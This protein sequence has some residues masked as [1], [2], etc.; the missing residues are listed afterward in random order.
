MGS[1]MYYSGEW[2]VKNSGKLPIFLRSIINTSFRE[3]YSSGLVK[4]FP[5]K[6]L[7]ANYT[8]FWSG[9]DYKQFEDEVIAKAVKGGFVSRIKK[10]TDSTFGELFKLTKSNYKTDWSKK[11]DKELLDYLD[12]I[13]ELE[14]KINLLWYTQYPFDDYFEYKITEFIRS[15][16]G[17]NKSK[18]DEYLSVLTYPSVLTETMKENIEIAKLSLNPS[19]IKEEDIERLQKKYGHLKFGLSKTEFPTTISDLKAR[20][21]SMDRESAKKILLENNLAAKSRVKKRVMDELKLPKEILRLNKDATIANNV[22]NTRIDN[23][24]RLRYNM[25]PV[26]R[27][28]AKRAG[29]D[30][31]RIMEWACWEIEKFLKEKKMVPEEEIKRRQQDYIILVDGDHNEIITEKSRMKVIIQEYHLNLQK[32]EELK[33]MIAYK[34]VA[35]GKARILMDASD[36]NKVQKGDIIVAQFTTPDFIMAME[37]SAAIIADQ[38]GITSHAAIVSRELKKPCIIDTKNATRMI[39]DGD[40]IEVDANK[41]IVRKIK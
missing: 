24:S 2:A 36:I 32:Q 12:R 30:Y 31:D 15:R 6:R 21:S 11:T 20:I 5:R 19:R 28:I 18:T 26:L 29:Q 13:M 40:L 37:K 23:Y 3:K 38:G 9:K 22:R 34:G 35:I 41:G 27:E 7:Y 14:R 16:I 33:G 25:V 4:K 39:K 8:M 1:G 10:V 17:S